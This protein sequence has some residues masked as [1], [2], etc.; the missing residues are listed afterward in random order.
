M[1]RDRYQLIIW[2]Q[3]GVLAYLSSDVIH[4]V[5]GHGATC[6][7]LGNQITLL[8][9]VYFK[10]QPGNVLVDLGG[11]IANL[12]CC[13]AILAALRVVKERIL[14]LFLVHLL[15]YNSFWF[16]G[17]ILQS[18]ISKTGDWTFAIRKLNLGQIEKYVLLVAGIL[19]YVV[20]SR[21]LRTYLHPLVRDRALT[22][23]D[24]LFPFLFAF[25][26]AFMA[27]LFFASG[28]LQAATE[29]MLEMAASFPILFLRL[30]YTRTNTDCTLN[31][32][33]SLVIT[34]LYI[35]FCLS[36]GRGLAF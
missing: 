8:T 34:I 22:R 9:S 32:K 20:V 27:G 11:P 6:W 23:Q 19:L 4:E 29:G 5:I 33:Y 14:I 21:L 2:A 17:T 35:G 28:R 26:S 7:W 13:M 12:L 16:T 30:N 18:A 10:S 31:Y 25:V 1:N 36:L 15:L 3:I 24:F